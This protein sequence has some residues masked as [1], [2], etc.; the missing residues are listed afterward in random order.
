MA[1]KNNH[2]RTLSALFQF[3]GQLK[4]QKVKQ[5]ALLRHLFELCC[6]DHGR[7]PPSDEGPILIPDFV[8]KAYAL[9]MGKWGGS[10]LALATFVSLAVFSIAGPPLLVA[11][12]SAAVGWL[13]GT[14]VICLVCQL[15]AVQIDNPETTRTANR[16][17]IAGGLLVTASVGCFA[18]ARLADSPYLDTLLPILSVAVE[19]GGLTF[20]AA[21]TA[22]E[23]VYRYPVELA[24][25]F[26]EA[27]REVRKLEQKQTAYTRMKGDSPH[28]SPNHLDP[29]NVENGQH[30]SD[31]AD[32]SVHQ[33]GKPNGSSDH[34]G[35]V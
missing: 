4:E 24:H 14:V 32:R 13:I 18:W 9:R 25:A 8:H 1:E 31:P 22:L 5:R 2:P 26:A 29:R 15:C 16:L 27:D 33:P 28:D 19:L 10:V 30:R 11:P 6:A 35:L 17:L 23:P 7:V 20:V 21:A 12:L 3:T 34:S